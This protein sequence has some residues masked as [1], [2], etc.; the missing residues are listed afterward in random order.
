[1]T[2]LPVDIT[3]SA[4]SQPLQHLLQFRILLQLT[5]DVAQQQLGKFLGILLRSGIQR[6]CDREIH[7]IKK[8]PIAELHHREDVL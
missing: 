1:L 3:V 7:R 4:L 2:N 8:A 5:L 6:E